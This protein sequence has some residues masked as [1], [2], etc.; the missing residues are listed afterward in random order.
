MMTCGDC[1]VVC[2][3]HEKHPDAIACDEFDGQ[4]E[5]AYIPEPKPV[6]ET[7]Y[8]DMMD[9]IVGLNARFVEHERRFNT[10]IA[11]IMKA[12]GPEEER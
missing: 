7:Q 3:G 5:E 10:I 6:T 9:V 8:K 1:Y 4:E 11:A 2:E 12:A